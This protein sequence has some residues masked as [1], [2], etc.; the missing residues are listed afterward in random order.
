MCGIA[1]VVSM[2]GG[3][4]GSA[5]DA[6]RRMTAHAIPVAPMRKGCGRVR[7]SSWATRRLAILDL[8]ARANQPRV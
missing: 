3:A 8:D 7:V 4:A 1:G 5:L 2:P 6:V